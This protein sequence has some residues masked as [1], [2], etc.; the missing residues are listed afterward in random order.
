MFIPEL[1]MPAGNFLKLQTAFAYGADAVYVGAAGFSMRPDEAS[2]TVEELKKAVDYTH[3]MRKKIYVALNILMFPEDINNLKKW[4]KETRSIPFDALIVSD[5]GAFSLIKEIRPELD[6]HISTQ[7]STANSAGA[8]FWKEAGAKR[9]ILARECTFEHIKEI[10][11]LK[12][13]EVEAFIHGAMCVAVSG[14][15]LLSAY[16]V[17][18]SGARGVCKH[19]CRWEW[20]LV[21]QK[22]PGLAFPVFEAGKNTIFLG[23]KDLCMIEHI[24]ELIDSGIKS[25]KVE[26]RM[27]S[28]HYV[29]NVARVYRAALD[30]YNINHK[31]YKVDPLW[32][33][34]LEAVSHRPYGTGFYFGYPYEEPQEL[35]TH[36]RPESTCEI[37]GIVEEVSGGIHTTNIKNS[38]E[39]GETIEWIAPGMTG[40]EVK[41]DKIY[42]EY[43][44]LLLKSQCGKNAFLSFLDNKVLPEFAIL[45]RRTVY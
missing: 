17:G 24:P 5:T 23:S 11:A 14:R 1:L 39:P 29:A 7:M 25:L 16:L 37:L 31:D 6:I 44:E 28:V 3:S 13:M 43:N 38:F 35:Q 12:G 42:S 40:G 34:E 22:R 45:R 10:S 36:N 27:K 18:H 30:S 21:E 32:L 2:F 15:C 20:Q 8:C 9:V 19:S 26:G 41:I 4:L 33:E